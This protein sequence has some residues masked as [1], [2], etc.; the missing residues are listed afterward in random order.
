MYLFGCLQMHFRI[1]KQNSSIL[2][3]RT[4][5]FRRCHE[6]LFQ[7]NFSFSFLLRI[8]IWN[9]PSEDYNQISI[10]M[11]NVAQ[12]ENLESV[13]GCVPLVPHQCLL[14]TLWDGGASKV[15]KSQQSSIF[16]SCLMLIMG[17]L[18]LHFAG[19]PGLAL[20]LDN[21]ETNGFANLEHKF[22]RSYSSSF[23]FTSSTSQIWLH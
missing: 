18:R 9:I 19:R 16:V 22:C 3:D 10:C 13:S 20:S 1:Q 4:V 21:P 2:K 11:L 14:C 17:V 15:E 12:P 23:V 7:H 8:S 5:L 6:R